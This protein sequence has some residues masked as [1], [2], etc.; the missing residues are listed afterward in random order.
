[1]KPRFDHDLFVI[2]RRQSSALASKLSSIWQPIWD[3]LVPVCRR[4]QTPHL[5]G[6]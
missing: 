4:S 6:L 5:S 2:V 3:S 1:M